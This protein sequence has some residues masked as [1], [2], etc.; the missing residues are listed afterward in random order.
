MDFR[1]PVS[2]IKEIALCSL[3][4]LQA[5]GFYGRPLKQAISKNHVVMGPPVNIGGDRSDSSPQQAGGYSR[6]FL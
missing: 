3:S 5:V 2:I 1:H 4:P 6:H